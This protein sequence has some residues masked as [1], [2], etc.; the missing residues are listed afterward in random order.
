MRP[1]LLLPSTSSSGAG[2]VADRRAIGGYGSLGYTLAI[3][4]GAAGIT[5]DEAEAVWA[6]VAVESDPESVGG[7]SA[8]V[9]RIVAEVSA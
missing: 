6:A 3:A 9:S 8:L 5:G 7:L 1:T 4:L 2:T